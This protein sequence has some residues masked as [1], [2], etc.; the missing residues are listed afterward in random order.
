M[1]AL[2]EYVLTGS[3]YGDMKKRVAIRQSV[4]GSK[5]L[6]VFI[7]VF[8][9]Y[10]SLKLSYPI[11]EKHKWLFPFYQVVR[12]CRLLFTKDAERSIAELKLALRNKEEDSVAATVVLKQL[13]LL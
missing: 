8:P 9:R 4:K 11:L 7:R 12:W 13:E 2:G 5:F 10:D 1:E 3:T 6:A